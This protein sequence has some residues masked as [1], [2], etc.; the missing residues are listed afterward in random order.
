MDTHKGDDDK[1]KDAKAG[2]MEEQKPDDG[3]E[4][5]KKKQPGKSG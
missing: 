1:G 2:E 4:Q 3:Q 5:T